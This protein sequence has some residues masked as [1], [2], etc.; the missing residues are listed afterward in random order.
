MKNLKNYSTGLMRSLKL[1]KNP[2]FM[3]DDLSSIPWTHIAEKENT[4]T[5]QNMTKELHYNTF[6][7]R[8]V[9]N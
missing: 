7:H 2:A 9:S 1:V 3:T 8:H 6:I 5:Q 4:H